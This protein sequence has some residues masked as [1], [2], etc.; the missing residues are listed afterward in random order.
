MLN[1]LPLLVL[2]A[3]LAPVW[4]CAMSESER[5]GMMMGA[6][7]GAVI[8]SEITLGAWLSKPTGQRQLLEAGVPTAAAGGALIGG[9]LGYWLTPDESR[10]S[11]CAVRAAEHTRIRTVEGSVI[12]A[13]LLGQ[14]PFIKW[15]ADS[16]AENEKTLQIGIPLFAIGGAVIGG[17]VG[18]LISRHENMISE[19]TADGKRCVQVASP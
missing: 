9:A 10:I 15:T 3:T 1:I 4:G 8:A 16:D 14:L 12:G 6:G 13:T 19:G 18:Y 11:D 2:L 7:T 17:A 5:Q